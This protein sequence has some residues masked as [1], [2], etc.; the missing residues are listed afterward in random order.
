M[1]SSDLHNLIYKSVFCYALNEIYQTLLSHLILHIKYF[2]VI[3]VTF[4]DTHNKIH[5]LKESS[6]NLNDQS[7]LTNEK[8]L[9]ILYIGV[10]ASSRYHI[11]RTSS[12]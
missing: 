1:R 5:I 3:R 11:T 8:C 6:I 7:T 12:S 2:L 4:L 10:L 9:P